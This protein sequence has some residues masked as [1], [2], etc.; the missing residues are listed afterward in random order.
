[1][2]IFYVLIFKTF[3]YLYLLRKAMKLDRE[4]ILKVKDEQVD[5]YH[6]SSE[7]ESKK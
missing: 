5:F 6:Y 3:L 4:L 1:M 7:R 2:Y